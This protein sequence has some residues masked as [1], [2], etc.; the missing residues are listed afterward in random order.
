ML[1]YG[2]QWKELQSQRQSHKTVTKVDALLINMQVAVL[3]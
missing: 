3:L 2:V 1:H